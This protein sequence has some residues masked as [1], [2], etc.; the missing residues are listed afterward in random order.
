MTFESDIR[1]AARAADSAVNTAMR[2]YSEAR[3]TDEP[4]ITGVLVGRL[5]A[6][7]DGGIGGL[8]WSSTIV[9]S[10]SGSAAEE[11]EIG[12]DLLLH[13]RL[14]AHGRS[15][16]KGLLVQA[17]RAEIG[18]RLSS[19]EAVRLHEQCRRTLNTTAASF[20]FVYATNQMRCGGA[21]S[22]FTGP[23]RDVHGNCPWTSYR[24]FLEFFR[25]PIGDPSIHGPLIKDLPVPHILSLKARG[26][27][28]P[29]DEPLIRVD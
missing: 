16:S 6:A 24:F 7:L 14:D 3:V 28:Q 5:D 4:D 21:A 17:K 26:R 10:S 9:R 1:A 25:C 18:E 12:A 20:V 19:K 27:D 15:F 13:V 22:F 29:E 8:E 2:K 11:K 23:R